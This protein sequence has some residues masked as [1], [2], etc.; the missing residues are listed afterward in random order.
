MARPSDGL[1][2]LPLLVVGLLIGIAGIAVLVYVFSGRIAGGI[3]AV[4]RWAWGLVIALVVLVVVGK[5][6]GGFSANARG[7]GLVDIKANPGQ[8]L[9]ISLA[10]EGKHTH[11]PSRV[12]G[13]PSPRGKF[14]ESLGVSTV[15]QALLAAG[16]LAAQARGIAAVTDHWV[17]LLTQQ[18]EPAARRR[19]RFGHLLNAP[20]DGWSRLKAGLAWRGHLLHHHNPHTDW[21][22]AP[23]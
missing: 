15:E 20:A 10:P 2:L 6:F 11:A 23:E 9:Q 12:E 13:Q 16:T 18:V 14:L 1:Y 19:L 17:N 22:A 7:F 5:I 3:G 8:P 4:P 21:P